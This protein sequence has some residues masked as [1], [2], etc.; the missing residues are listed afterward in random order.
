M[1]RRSTRRRST[2]EEAAMGRFRSEVLAAAMLAALSPQAATA[3]ASDTSASAAQSAFDR[4]AAQLVDLF[5]GRIAYSAYFDPPFKAAVSEA[6]FDAFRDSLTAQH[7]QPVAVDKA[8]PTSDRPG[9]VP[10]SLN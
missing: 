6:P 1:P 7:G 2:L 8:E 5:G 9:T 10:L 3:Q 4:R